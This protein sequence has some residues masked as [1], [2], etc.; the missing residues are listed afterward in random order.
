[1]MKKSRSD[2]PQVPGPRH[3][4]KRDEERE[5]KAQL[6]AR[7]LDQLSAGVLAGDKV[8]ATFKPGLVLRHDLSVLR[9]GTRSNGTRTRRTM[10]C[11]RM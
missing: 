4:L 9:A 11:W 8:D 6:R 2:A 3:Q 5:K 7:H 1:M 10:T